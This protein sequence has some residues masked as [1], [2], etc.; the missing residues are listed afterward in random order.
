[1]MMARAAANDDLA[2]VV[3][4][5]ASE[6]ELRARTIFRTRYGQGEDEH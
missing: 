5:N 4:I 6:A 3:S 2:I 1:M